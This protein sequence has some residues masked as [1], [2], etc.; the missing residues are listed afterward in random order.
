V[1]LFACEKCDAVENTA[2]SNYWTRNLDDP[3]GPK[4]PA[5]CS[6]CDPAIGTW[7]GRFPK[8]TAKAAGYVVGRDGFLCTPD[9]AKRKDGP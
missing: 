4:K 3:K 2:L 5:L 6:E 7:H 9:E 1:S 8:E